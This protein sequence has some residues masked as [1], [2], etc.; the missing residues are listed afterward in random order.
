LS[1]AFFETERHFVFLRLVF[2][3]ICVWFLRLFA[4]GF[5]LF[6]VCSALVFV[7]RAFNRCVLSYFEFAFLNMA[8][9]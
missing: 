3:P 4:F 6:Q 5:A 9:F 8:L 7:I 1:C 2:A